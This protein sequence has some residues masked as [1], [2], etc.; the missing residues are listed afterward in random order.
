MLAIV[1]K[2]SVMLLR[3]ALLDKWKHEVTH[4]L[5][6]AV[7]QAIP[8]VYLNTGKQGSFADVTSKRIRFNGKQTFRWIAKGREHQLRAIM[9]HEIGHLLNGDTNVKVD[10]CSY[11][12]SSYKMP[13][14][15]REVTA[16]ETA[17]MLLIIHGHDPRAVMTE[18]RWHRDQR[19]VDRIVCIV[20]F[21]E[22]NYLY[23]PRT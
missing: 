5:P 2:E 18:L 10:L 7:Q 20:D 9:A 3:S 11:G 1:S 4:R 21:L 6:L 22:Q 15:H 14:L 17:M 19:L 13:H 16:W 12:W 8:P 23:S